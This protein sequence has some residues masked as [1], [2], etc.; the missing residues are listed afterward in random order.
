MSK[1]LK[2]S[3]IRRFMK[4]ASIGTLSEEFVTERY[5]SKKD[6]YHRE[7]EGGV[8]TKT[9]DVGKY[10][11]GGHY[12]DYEMNEAEED[13]LEATEDELGAEDEFADEEAGEIDD[14]EGDLGDEGSDAE[15]AVLDIVSTIT[16]ALAQEY[17]LDIDVESDEGGEEADIEGDEAEVELDVE[18]E[19][20]EEL[21]DVEVVDDEEVI[22][23]VLRRVTA[24]LKK[25]IK[26]NK[27][28]KISR[29]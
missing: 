8:E 17:D 5:G 10:G 25:A 20:G 23:E 28:T 1:V 11:K 26:E 21:E 9:G 19:G 14:L 16:N 12:K 15:P 2:E 22:A 24:R 3:Q 29:K 4:L 13:E 7:E 27:K 6:E 18:D